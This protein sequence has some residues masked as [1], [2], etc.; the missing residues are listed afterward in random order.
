MMSNITTNPGIHNFEGFLSS[1]PLDDV[2]DSDTVITAGQRNHVGNQMSQ[3]NCVILIEPVSLLDGENCQSAPGQD[4]L[5]RFLSNDLALSKALATSAFGK[6]GISSMSKN[7]ARNLLI[8]NMKTS[9]GVSHLLEVE[10]LGMWKIKC[11]LPASQTTSAGVIGPFGS[12]VSN[13]E[14]TEALTSAGHLGVTAERILKGKELIR[15]SMFKV[16]FPCSSL[17]SHVTIGYQRFQVNMFVDKPWQCFRCQRFGHNALTCRSPPRCV[18]CGGSHGVKTCAHVGAPKCCNCG[19]AHTASY[20]GCPSMKQAKTIE[21]TRTM[22]KCSYR[23]AVKHVQTEQVT[24]QASFPSHSTG[25]YNFSGSQFPQLPASPT[26]TWNLSGGNNS[27]LSYSAQAQ[28]AKCSVSTQTTEPTQQTVEAKISLTQLIDLLSRVLSLCNNSDS[29]ATKETITKIAAETFKLNPSAESRDTS[30]LGLVVPETSNPQN[31]E[32]QAVMPSHDPAPM[33][34]LETAMDDSDIFIEDGQITPSPIL[35]GAI[36]KKKQKTYP[37]RPS[38]VIG[39]K[40]QPKTT[41]KQQRI[42]LKA[43]VTSLKHNPGKCQ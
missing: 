23:D 17:P 40:P 2:S 34:S 6:I 16:T 11:R 35:G 32:T 10:K 31:T 42:F 20:G 28:K 39:G 24:N 15:T 5:S 12:E 33:L 14:L 41:G 19:G 30:A 29:T 18:V 7:I 25:I 36:S 26:R 27:N 22:F 13:E 37:L 9:Q 4:D 3:Q 1:L 38:P 8:L 43:A 21:K